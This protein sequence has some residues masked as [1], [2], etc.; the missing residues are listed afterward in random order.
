MR[1]DDAAYSVD[2][3]IPGQRSTMKSA[4]RKSPF[5]MPSRDPN[6]RLIRPSF[7]KKRF[8]IS[9]AT[10]EKVSPS[11]SN[12]IFGSDLRSRMS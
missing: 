6:K 4:D 10:F 12:I 8:A 7:F 5:G 11:G 2:K 3:V 9:S 1:A